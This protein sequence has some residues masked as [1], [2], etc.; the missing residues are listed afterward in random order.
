MRRRC[1]LSPWLRQMRATLWGEMPTSRASERVL[2]RCRPG[3]AL[4]ASSTTRR[5]VASGID[6]LAPRPGLSLRPSSP[7]WSKRCDHLV[8]LGALTP[9]RDATSCCPTPSLR[10]R[11]MCARMQS[12]AG[13][14]EAPT[15]RSNSRFS[16]GVT[17]ITEIGRA[18]A[19]LPPA[20]DLPT[21]PFQRAQPPDAAEPTLPSAIRPT[22]VLPSHRT[23]G[24][25]RGRHRHD[26]LRKWITAARKP[27]QGPSR[28]V[29]ASQQSMWVATADL[30]QGS[31]HPFY[32]RLNQILNAAGFDAFV[33]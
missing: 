5:T 9:K 22:S 27:I 17:S 26:V 23:R 25:S 11:T 30:P 24:V 33:E 19:S 3:S 31:G 28:I 6:G 15:R 7:S 16:S 14:V 12:R 10:S 18:I 20:A 29:R 2:Q 4:P 21:S 13:V 1:G 32:E 8:T